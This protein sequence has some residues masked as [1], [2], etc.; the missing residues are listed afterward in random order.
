MICAHLTNYVL[1]ILSCKYLSVVPLANTLANF[2][3]LDLELRS[4]FLCLFLGLLNFLFDLSRS[5]LVGLS[6]QLDN[7]LFLFLHL[8]DHPRGFRLT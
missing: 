4:L 2:E 5:L 3:I 7:P 6:H 1:F 8:K